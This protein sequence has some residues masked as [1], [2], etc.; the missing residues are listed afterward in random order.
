MRFPHNRV[1]VSKQTIGTGVQSDTLR[2]NFPAKLP[3]RIFAG[4]FRRS[5]SDCT[6]VPMVCFETVTRLCGNRM[7]HFCSISLCARINSG[8][9]CLVR[10]YNVA[11]TSVTFTASMSNG[12]NECERTRRWCEPDCHRT[13]WREIEVLVEHVQVRTANQ[14]DGSGL[15]YR[16]STL[17]PS[18]IRIRLTL[19]NC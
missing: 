19:L 4:K 14:R 17:D 8:Q 16:L 11:C 18:R 6:P 3:K 9:T 7:L 1:T 5:V 10:T 2:L 15:Q 12:T 13:A